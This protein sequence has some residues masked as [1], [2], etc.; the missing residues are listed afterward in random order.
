M[1][2]AFGDNIYFKDSEGIWQQQNSHH[3]Y[4][5]GSPN[6]FNIAHDTSADRI[7]ISSN[8]AYWGSAGP[9]IPH[10]FRNYSGFDLRAGRGHKCRF[11]KMLIEDFVSWFQSLKVAGY[12]DAPAEWS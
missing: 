8:F 10:Q 3:S 11:P 12:L 2:Q 5:D 4:G 6:Q 1:K 7:L 9:R